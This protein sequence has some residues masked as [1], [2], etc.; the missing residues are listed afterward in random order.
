MQYT[1]N[2]K[3]TLQQRASTTT[4]T[5][6]YIA[7]IQLWTENLGNLATLGQRGVQET[8]KDRRELDTTLDVQQ[9]GLRLSCKATGL[10]PARLE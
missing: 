1:C 7:F 4:R 5:S 8:A 10:K 6:N 3:C 9:L 2:C